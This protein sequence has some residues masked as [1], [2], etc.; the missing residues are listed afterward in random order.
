VFLF[1]DGE[2]KSL[3]RPGDVLGDVEES[4]G[5]LQYSLTSPECII[6]VLVA[7]K[8]QRVENFCADRSV[9]EFENKDKRI[10]GAQ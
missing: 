1:A 6:V 4:Q 9:V 7:A 10:Q 2:N 3:K 5:L 8:R